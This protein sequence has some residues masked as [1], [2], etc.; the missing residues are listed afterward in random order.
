MLIENIYIL[1]INKEF[2]YSVF[3]VRMSEWLYGCSASEILAFWGA[4]V[5]KRKEGV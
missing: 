2:L 1:I 4:L 3:H 5:G